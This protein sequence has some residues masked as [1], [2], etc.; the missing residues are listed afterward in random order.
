MSI[1]YPIRSWTS[2]SM[3]ISYNRCFCF[4]SFS[5]SFLIA[6]SSRFEKTIATIPKIMVAKIAIPITIY[7]AIMVNSSCLL[8]HDRDD[9]LH[10]AGYGLQVWFHL[11]GLLFVDSQSSLHGFVPDLNLWT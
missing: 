10:V 9:V 4:F 8:F 1:E 3:V 2:F 11:D 7:I 6:F 5:T